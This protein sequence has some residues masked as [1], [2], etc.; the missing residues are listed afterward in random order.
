MWLE[1]SHQPSRQPAPTSYTK[2]IFL[3]CALSLIFDILSD[4]ISAGRGG[5]PLYHSQHDPYPTP[6]G[7]R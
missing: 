1:L 7:T 4:T 6:S 3:A 2:F 5:I